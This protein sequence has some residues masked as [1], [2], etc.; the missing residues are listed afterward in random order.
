MFGKFVIDKSIYEYDPKNL[1]NEFVQDYNKV[2]NESIT[3][4]NLATSLMGANSGDQ[5]KDNLEI[6]NLYLFLNSD[7][8]INKWG[9][10]F[11]YL[12]TKTTNNYA[13]TQNDLLKGKSTNYSLWYG[14]RHLLSRLQNFFTM[15]KVT[16]TSYVGADFLEEANYSDLKTYIDS[17]ETKGVYSCGE[18]NFNKIGENVTLP[19]ALKAE[20]GY[21][22][23][24]W[25]LEET[26]YESNETYKVTNLNVKFEPRFTELTF[27]ID[28]RLESSK[29]ELTTFINSIG[30][31]KQNIA[32]PTSNK[33]YSTTISYSSSNTDVLSN[34]GVF[35]RPYK[36]TTVTLTATISYNGNS[37]TETYK[38]DIDGYKKLE[39][40][41][42]SY[43]YT[44][45]DKVSDEFFET[46]DII[47]CAFMLIDVDGG[48]TGK[49]GEG[50]SISS[51][52]T[53]YKNYMKN[54]ILPKAHANGDWVVISIGGGGSAY[55]KAFEA[56]C[57][58]NAKIDTL[59]KNIIALINE[60]GFDGVDIDWEIPDTGTD[61]T[62][63][64][65]KLYPAVKAN[66][67]NHIVT[68][69]I[70]GGKWQPPK[71]DLIN[72][73]KYLDF[74]NVMTY[75]M[76]SES[77]YHHTALYKS[78]TYFDPTNKVAKTLVSCS[79]EE[80]VKI[81]ND[82]Y[83]IPSSK[84][85]VGGAFYASKQTRTSKDATWKS[86]GS[87]SYTNIKNTYLKDPNYTYYY[88]TNCQ[89][90]YL[91]SK[92]GLTFISYDDPTS[93]KV[94]CEYILK[95]D[96]AGFMYWQNGQDTTGDLVKA[97]KEGLKK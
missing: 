14:G 66:N 54:Y 36:P 15:T 30:E 19:S 71:Y 72:S 73:G 68:A 46:M 28:N 39:N 63:L 93:I 9:W 60:C 7:G 82:T 80:S 56:I 62:K 5:T 92:D 87:I 47:Y 50:N 34:T 21:Q 48:F 16:A 2:M 97:I 25:Y 95:N 18:Y 59:V 23:D 79:I 65:E 69:A 52:N 11:D 53:R 61:F 43:V 29:L 17:L 64:M 31:I 85:I 94:K 8:M 32:L 57:D 78:S 12:V 70:G 38:F 58:D 40:I 76:A 75:S 1:G 27:S 37:V 83:G 84:L 67:P 90:P 35:N 42:S 26:K 77:G 13:K 10:L 91:L 24:G 74:I 33:T 86:S 3:I 41:A 55:D 4:N 45:Y 49:D 89:A 20:E 88:D 44:N 81:Y 96:L 51:T 22:F 6:S